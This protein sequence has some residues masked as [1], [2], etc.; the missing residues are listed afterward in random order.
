MI[1]LTIVCVAQAVLLGVVLWLQHKERATL[2]Q[3]IQAPGVAVA[4]HQMRD[5]PPSP[6][7]VGWDDDEAHHLSR[8]EM[9]ER[10]R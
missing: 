3:R 10:L 4:A 6:P 7:A 5:L 9:A 2:L 1:Y 8:E